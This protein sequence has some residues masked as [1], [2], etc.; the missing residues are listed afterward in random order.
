VPVTIGFLITPVASVFFLPFL[1][2]VTIMT[3]LFILLSSSSSVVPDPNVQ[4]ICTIR[5]SIV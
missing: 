5:A 1:Y 2:K 3:V 4:I